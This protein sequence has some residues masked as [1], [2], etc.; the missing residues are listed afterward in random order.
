MGE[1]C[2][3]LQLKS[4][5]FG[6]ETIFENTRS[7][8]IELSYSSSYPSNVSGL[9][10]SYLSF[11]HL[12]L[13]SAASLHVFSSAGALRRRSQKPLYFCL[14]LRLYL[15]SSYAVKFPVDFDFIL[16]TIQSGTQLAR[17]MWRR[18]IWQR[19]WGISFFFFFFSPSP[20]DHHVYYR[21]SVVPSFAIFPGN[22]N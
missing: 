14:A 4:N 7:V 6:H 10:L 22:A 2:I 15:T 9:Y 17:S 16:M 21:D 18:V 13:T 1:A 11:S 3:I 12:I 8:G 5:I 20:A 19:R